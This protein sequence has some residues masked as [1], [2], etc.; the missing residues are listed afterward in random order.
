MGS[1]V[2]KKMQTLGV[3][4]P[5]DVLFNEIMDPLLDI[6]GYRKV[7]VEDDHNVYRFDAQALKACPKTSY[8]SI[9]DKNFKAAGGNNPG[10]SNLVQG[11][12]DGEKLGS[13]FR[14]AQNIPKLGA[15]GG[16]LTSAHIGRGRT[17]K[18][19][20][21]DELLVRAR[22]ICWLADGKNRGQAIKD[23]CEFELYSSTRSRV[24]TPRTPRG[25]TQANSIDKII[26]NARNDVKKIFEKNKETIKKFP[27]CAF[28]KMINVIALGRENEISL[29]ENKATATPNPVT[30][31]EFIKKTDG[32]D[33]REYKRLC[34]RE[35]PYLTDA[36]I[37]EILL[38]YA[39]HFPD[40][41]TAS[42]DVD[43]REALRV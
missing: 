31:I 4:N 33:R 8:K 5:K 34:G 12:A 11:G 29:Y 36:D 22:M 23:I 21:N 30:I 37:D 9:I 7:L 40:T 35:W 39:K 15:G 27:E 41:I 16:T 14:T 28:T 32:E 24:L 3:V 10:F 42:V 17:P 2:N 18:R 19:N 25:A 1:K 38:M 20:N 6:F 43:L 13:P 26:S